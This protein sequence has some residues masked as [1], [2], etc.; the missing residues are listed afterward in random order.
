MYCVG[1]YLKCKCLLILQ[2]A[3]V[4][5]GQRNGLSEKDILKLELMYKTDENSSYTPRSQ[6]IT[7]IIV[8][9]NVLT[10]SN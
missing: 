1:P 7:L 5:I 2:D 9:L 3:N 4:Q 6:F 10:H 8:T